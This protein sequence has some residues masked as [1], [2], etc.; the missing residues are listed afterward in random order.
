MMRVFESMP[1]VE[2]IIEPMLLFC[3]DSVVFHAFVLCAVCRRVYASLLIEYIEFSAPF[4]LSRSNLS[5]SCL[6]SNC[7]C[8]DI[9]A[10][11]SKF[12][13]RVLIRVLLSCCV[14]VEC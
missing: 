14:A 3:I 9:I 2:C 1:S 4:S 13:S 11:L 12:I 10:V 6:I 8:G 7:V 5:C